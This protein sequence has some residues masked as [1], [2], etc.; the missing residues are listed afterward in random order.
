MMRDPYR[1]THVD[2]LFTYEHKA[3]EMETMCLVKNELERRGYTV[4]ITT[5]YFEPRM[6]FV[7]RR[8]PKV[9]LTPALYNDNGLF[10]FVYWVAGPC[11]KVV[12]MQWEQ[13][14]TNQDESDPSFF[15]NPKGS[16]RE[17]VHLCW[18]EEPQRRLM[19]AGVP[20]DKAVIVGPPQMDAVRSDMRLMHM[21]RE[22]L[23][24]LSGLDPAREWVLFTSSFTFVSMT[25][26][27]F[28]TELKSIGPS[29][30]EFVEVSV[31]SQKAILDWFV[32]ACRTFPEKIFVYRPHPSEVAAPQLK[33]LEAAHSNFRVI[34]DF[35]VRQW[36]VCADQ[37]FTWYSTS[38]AE[39]YFAGKPCVVLRPVT[40]PIALDVS[41]FRGAKMI[42][43][44]DQFIDAVAG[45]DTSFALDPDL[46]AKYF[47]VVPLRPTYLRVCDVLE[48]VLRTDRYDMPPI[49]RARALYYYLQ[50]IRHRAF[51][52]A[53]EALATRALRPFRA[54]PW[55]KRRVDNHESLTHRMRTHRPRSFATVEDLAAMDAVINEIR[56]SSN[57][58]S[59]AV[60]S[61]L[62]SS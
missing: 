39:A 4:G 44:A 46:L 40:I 59:T 23:A 21:S 25:P 8:W 16:A 58:R 9:V 61:C 19:R 54:I 47:A 17:A 18:G 36:I 14:L 29:L 26:E 33:A 12:N 32:Q 49:S 3:R 56:D 52:V 10:A 41:I 30:R 11:R 5:T 34:T 2:F 13:A 42:E 43:R 6:R 15:Q 35:S 20:R 38:A 50:R 48:D 31:A 28:E 45:R 57:P 27:E 62:S 51:F 53:K 1:A 60:E 24:E 37:I 7:D 22:R 55:I